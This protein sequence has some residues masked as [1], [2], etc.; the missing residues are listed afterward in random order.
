[1]LGSSSEVGSTRTNTPST[2][3]S[4]VPSDENQWIKRPPLG[5]LYDPSKA[6]D[7]AALSQELTPKEIGMLVDYLNMW[8]KNIQGLLDK[9]KETIPGDGMIGEVHY[10]RDMSRILDAINEEVK[11]K[12]VE[13]TL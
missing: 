2:T 4:E 11:Q 12:Y 7:P 1:M 13:V 8:A 3:F 6:A 9:L 10:W 5:K